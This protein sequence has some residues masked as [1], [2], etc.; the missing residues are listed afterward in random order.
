MKRIFLFPTVAE[1]RDFILSQPKDPVFVTG[2][3]AA[4]VAAGTIRAFRAKKPALAVLAGAA[5]AL[6]PSLSPGEVVEVTSGCETG[7]GDQSCWEVAPL[8][9]LRNVGSATAAEAGAQ[10]V[11]REGSAFMAVCEALG[12]EGCEIRAVTHCGDGAADEPALQRAAA[13]LS[14]YLT[15]TEITI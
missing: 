11:S 13:A 2:E 10:L 3:G 1:A 15:Q 6:D 14:E 8:T 4:A 9:R 7:V 12:I 5:T